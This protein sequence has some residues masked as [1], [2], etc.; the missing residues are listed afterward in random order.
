MPSFP[1][2]LFPKKSSPKRSSPKRSLPS[3]LIVW[4]AIAFSLVVL[5]KLIN[6]QS[7]NAAHIPFSQFLDEIQAQKITEVKLRGKQV[8][9]LYQDKSPFQTMIPL[10]YEDLV[11]ALLNNGV[12]VKAESLPKNNLWLIAL[13]N[14]IPILLV[15]GV[16]FFLMRQ[17]QSGGNR[18][19]NFGKIRT[20]KEPEKPKITFKD[21]AGIDEARAELSEVVEYLREPSKFKKLG[22]EIP[23]GVLLIGLPGTGKT[24]LAKAVAGES[25]VPFFNISGSDFLEMFV[26]VGASRVRDLFQKGRQNAP[27]IIFVDEI[28]AVGRQRGSGLGGGHD[29]REQTLNQMLVEMDGFPPN[30]GVIIIAA[31]NRADVLDP[32]LLRP[33]RFDRHVHI[34]LPDING[35][36][37]ILKVHTTKV[38]LHA[39]VKLRNIAAGTPGFSGADLANLVNESA[40]WAARQKKK[41]VFQEDLEFAKDKVLMGP[42]R[43]SMLISDEERKTTAYHEAGHALVATLLPEVYPVHKVTIIPHGQALGVTQTLPTEDRHYH[44]RTELLQ[45]MAMMLGGRAA[46]ELTFKHFT[47]G[48]YDDIKKVTE[49][50]NRMVTQWGMSDAFGPVNLKQSNDDSSLGH[51][52]LS[53]SIISEKTTRLVDEE[54]SKLVSACYQKAIQLLRKHRSILLKIANLLLEEETIDSQKIQQLVKKVSPV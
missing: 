25:K 34:P 28:D 36:E 21:V 20:K 24:M 1:K 15:V 14:W 51:D 17:I 52:L 3:G 9:G 42:E 8:L 50:A 49:L 38:R 43:K 37:A 44:S 2:K 7:K 30:S 35:R 4:I 54:I 12:K 11:P 39:D 27:C 41:R 33:G 19:L 29:E 16:F 5:F 47:T 18:A 22:G 48:A 46:E 31:T 32:A 23:R 40:L 45:T 26:G 6:N 10:H 13:G 53:H